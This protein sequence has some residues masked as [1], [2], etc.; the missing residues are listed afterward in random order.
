MGDKL[1]RVETVPTVERPAK[2]RTGK[3][4]TAVRVSKVGSVFFLKALVSF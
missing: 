2:N 4:E 1:E 3:P